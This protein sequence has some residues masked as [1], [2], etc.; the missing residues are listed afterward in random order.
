MKRTQG[1]ARPGCAHEAPQLVGIHA[2]V[3]ADSGIKGPTCQRALAAGIGDDPLPRV[4]RVWVQAQEVQRGLDV[5]GGD[6]GRTYGHDG[7]ALVSA[8]A[9]RLCAAAA[10]TAVERGDASCRC[11]CATSIGSIPAASTAAGTSSAA[12]LIRRVADRTC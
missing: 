10:A 6:D 7:D 1:R 8:A 4:G 12:V 9:A 11:A 2:D 5:P 3:G